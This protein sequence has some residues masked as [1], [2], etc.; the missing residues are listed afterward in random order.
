MQESH[1]FRIEWRVTRF[2]GVLARAN[3][4]QQKEPLPIARSPKFL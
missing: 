3:V 1:G 2:N 4:K